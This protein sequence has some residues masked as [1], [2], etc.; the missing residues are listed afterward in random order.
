MDDLISRQ[1]AIET[2]R[3]AKNLYQAHKMLVQ[4]PAAQQETSILTVKCELDDE[5]LSRVIEAVKNAELELIAAQPEIIYCK[6]CEHWTRTYGDEQ[7][8]LGDCDVFDKHLVMCNG[9][10]A[11]AER[12]TDD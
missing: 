7:W 4:L 11:W 2:V 5:E 6:K 1:D 12:R 9:Y 10:C 8:G 3:K